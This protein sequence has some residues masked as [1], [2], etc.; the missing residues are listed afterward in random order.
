MS[1][2]A[3]TGLFG[4]YLGNPR[5][6]RAYAATPPCSGTAPTFTCNVDNQ[7]E[8]KDAVTFINSNA[9][10]NT[11][12]T[13][14]INSDFIVDEALTRTSKIAGANFN[15]VA[16]VSITIDGNNH[17]VSGDP[18]KSQ[19][20]FLNLELSGIGSEAIAPDITVRDLTIDGMRNIGRTL[21]NNENFPAF[22]IQ[23]G[24]DHPRGTVTISDVSVTNTVVETPTSYWNS[25]AY[26]NARSISVSD[27]AFTNNSIERTTAGDIW[28]GAG[29]IVY[30][31][32]RAP[33]SGA[34]IS[35]STFSGN[36]ATATG[37]VTGSALHLYNYQTGS[38]TSIVNST[39][40][41]NRAES[42]G[43]GGYARGAGLSTYNADLEVS[44][45][46]FT[47]NVATSQDMSKGAAILA[48]SLFG[49]D[50]SLSVTDSAF[51]G[52]EAAVTSGGSASRVRGGAIYSR[53]K[54]NGT[55]IESSTFT[56]NTATTDAGIAE[57]GAAFINATN[58]AQAV[59]LT[60]SL[61]NGNTINAPEGSGGAV[62]TSTAP[63]TVTSSEF[64]N[65]SVTAA[66]GRADGGALRAG[67]DAVGTT[68]DSSTFSGNSASTT[69]NGQGGAVRLDPNSSGQTLAIVNS[70][71]TS[72]TMAGGTTAGTG[73]SGGAIFA[74]PA[75]LVVEYTTITENHATGN[76]GEGGGLWSYNPTIR[77]SIVNRNTA[78]QFGDD[79]SGLYSLTS[80]NSLFTSNSALHIIAGG[81]PTVIDSLY[82]AD[83][84]VDAPAD[85]GGLAIGRIGTPQVIRTM[86]LRS[87][88][89]AN[90]AG[91]ASVGT[92]PS[93]DE[94]GTGF[95]RVIGACPDAG[96]FEGSTTACYSPTPPA[97][98]APAPSGGGSSDSA[99]ADVTLALDGNGG[100]V[101][102][103]SVV[104]SAG[105]SVMLPTAGQASR[106]GY[107]LTG[108]STNPNGSGATYAPGARL[109]LAVSGTLFAQ[110]APV[111]GP[112]DPVVTPATTG[113][114][115][116]GSVALLDGAPTPSSVAA[117]AKGDALDVTGPGW[118]LALSGS[119][120]AGA[121]QPLQAGRI[122]LPAGGSV[123][124]SGS[125]YAPGTQVVLYLL[126]PAITLGTATVGA[127][128]SFTV[129]L[130]VPLTVGAGRFVLQANGMT[131]GNQVRSV[132]VPVTVRGATA[133]QRVQ[134]VSA[135]I[136]FASGSSRL[137]TTAQRTL[138]RLE[139][140]VP[141][142]AKDV[143]VQCIG[144]VQPTRNTGNDQTLS[145]Q[146]A[147]NSCEQL[148][149]D[150]VRG[151]QVVSGKGRAP[152]TNATARRVEI[153]IAY[154]R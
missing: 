25:A 147:V 60:K 104:G 6:P 40:T 132:S 118:N 109:T 26:I 66:T 103:P 140:R 52:N 34:T 88:A 123:R 68:I 98:P 10:A 30:T 136:Y 67:T 111:T 9:A 87:G 141:A 122:V 139:A 29:L 92:Q 18:T 8:F 119:T 27:S 110:W 3:T 21:F 95:P 20:T 28:G 49:G 146:R 59:A 13:M 154:R 76:G 138:E 42:T 143:T 51:T 79:A 1:L 117:N 128:G 22:E 82:S 11:S 58:S 81:S 120:S 75:P 55:V 62:A 45:S 86:A 94:R 72:N 108:W 17:V 43:V 61:F 89:M 69:D 91:S 106:P 70:T 133:K 50:V 14:E 38:P 126:D 37:K 2:V 31:S 71:F 19:A 39:F 16:G 36:T 124:A 65:N 149:A 115:A 100:S 32:S 144:F 96:A 41:G 74:G 134:R 129:V 7:T 23:A 35:N 125:G 15:N 114:P 152:Q 57:G 113:V 83:A 148:R 151:S 142:G 93:T 153:T 47:D 12:F 135:T 101:A 48:A 97:P 4:S 112:L 63:L 24:S 5:P 150:G 131:T 102:V 33:G 46:V 107:V 54:I 116:G 99:P 90:G 127:D 85:N 78:P 105:S 145:T 77:N 130:T 121:A 137:T 73:A 44:G 53:S 64:T 80:Q 56:N 84:Q